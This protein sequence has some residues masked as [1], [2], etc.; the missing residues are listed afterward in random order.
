ML[1]VKNLSG[2]YNAGFIVSNV[3]FNLNTGENLFFI[4][5]N[6]S[7]KTTLFKIILGLI[8]KTNGKVT[9]NGKAINK[10][11]DRA[12]HVGY[13]PQI[14]EQPFDYSVF[15]MVLMGRS[16]HI[17][18]FST[19]SKKDI[20]I[21]KDAIEMLGITNLRHK[22]F[23]HLSGGEMKMVLIARAICQQAKIIVMDEPYANLDYKNQSQLSKAIKWLNNKGYSFIIS[24]HNV[25]HIDTN[26]NSVLLKNGKQLGFGPSSKLLN[27]KSLTE[28]FETP[29]IV[30]KI[31]SDNGDMQFVCT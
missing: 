28:L 3:N 2:G 16:S 26:S 18:M 17:N 15:E 4:G 30:T 31:K 22:S 21:T 25:A 29:M 10:I 20:A 6:G 27:N 14:H 23:N 7:G 24:T 8:T 1:N 19:A 12:H 11:N 5:P 13:I 9:L